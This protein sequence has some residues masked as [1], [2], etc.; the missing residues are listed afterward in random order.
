MKEYQQAHFRIA[1]S[2]ATMEENG[3]PCRDNPL[4]LNPL[5]SVSSLSIPAKLPA[6]IAGQSQTTLGNPTVFSKNTT[7]AGY[8]G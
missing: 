4:W 2:Q 1:V 5:H 8:D 6:P 3:T 7:M